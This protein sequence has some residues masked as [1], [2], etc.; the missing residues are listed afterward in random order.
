MYLWLMLV[1]HRPR[2]C[3]IEFY[4]TVHKDPQNLRREVFVSSAMTSESRLTLKIR[5]LAGDWN[6]AQTIL[7]NCADTLLQLCQL[8]PHDTED[9]S[10]GGALVLSWTVRVVNHSHW[11]AAPGCGHCSCCGSS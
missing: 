6:V 4:T 9:R 8:H 3:T 2:Q 7:W 5:E 1:L 10:G 11:S